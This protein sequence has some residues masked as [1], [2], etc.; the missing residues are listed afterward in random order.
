MKSLRY[1]LRT[2]WLTR[3]AQAACRRADYVISAIHAGV[4]VSVAVARSKSLL[5]AAQNW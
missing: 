2:W 3:Q 5:F 4:P 1:R